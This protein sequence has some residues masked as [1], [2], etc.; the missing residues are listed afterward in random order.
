MDDPATSHDVNVNGTLTMLQAARN[1]GVKRFVFASS[2]SIYGERPESPKHESM[3]ALPASPYAATKAAG[4]LYLQAWAAA[5]GMETLALRYFN[6]FGPRQDP[7]GPYAAVIPAFAGS[8]INGRRPVVYGDGEQSRDFCH[9]E[10]ACLA[11]WLA[12]Q[13]PVEVCDGRA[14]NV[15]CGD[16]TTLNRIL[17]IL[18]ELLDTKIDPEYQD[19]RPGDVKHSL[20]DIS[21]AKETI[22]YEPVIYFEEGLRAA[23]DWYRQ[24]L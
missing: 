6:V 1:A 7:E 18:S 8:I 22:G 20:A 12:L 10:N 16:S 19:P 13:A 9:I 11:N 24:N 14:V 23:I 4:E 15:A 2:S 21:R 3:L 5:F 17:E